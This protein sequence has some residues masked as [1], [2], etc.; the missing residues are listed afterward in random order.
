VLDGTQSADFAIWLVA[1]LLY[2]WDAA[3]LLSTRQLLLVEAG[4]ERFATVFSESPFMIAGRVLAFSPL[5]LPHRGV[6]IAPWG[7]PWAEP[8][9]LGVTLQTIG[10]LRDSLLPVRVLATWS[11]A[12]LFVV[13]PA[14]TLVTGP[15][16]AVVYTAIAVYWTAFVAILVLW[17]QRGPFRLS[18]RQATWLS[19]DLLICPAFLPNLVRKVTLTCPI[20]ADG[21]QIL[22]ATATPDVK[23]RFVVQLVSRTE[24]LLETVSP[25]EREGPG[26]RSYVDEVRAA[27]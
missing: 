10:R 11:F 18:Q 17:W 9:A 1:G 4:R 2:T 13:G 6:F 3:K 14:L 20:E 21:P 19:I 23:E 15:N 22:F 27:Q 16:A 25:D 26:L 8:A 24:D 7:R 5:F 12:L